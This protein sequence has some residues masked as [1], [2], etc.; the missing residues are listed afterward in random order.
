LRLTQRIASHKLTI[1]ASEFVPQPGDVLSYKWS[2]P[3]GEA[4]ERQMPPFCLTNLDK[5][6]TQIVHY[7]KS[8]KWEYLASL[9][10]EDP[11]AWMTVSTAMQYARSRP[12]RTVPL[13]LPLPP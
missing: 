6:H 11:L 3:P 12:V 9:E 5:V 4:Y 1:Y 8:A 10:S 7:I 13:V 2:D